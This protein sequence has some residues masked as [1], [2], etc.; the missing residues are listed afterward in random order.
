MP[1]EAKGPS[2]TALKTQVKELKD[3]VAQL[4]WHHAELLHLVRTMIARQAAA[5]MAPAMQSKLEAEIM[6]KLAGN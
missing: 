5:Q 4:A 3:D 1:T 2:P 6:E